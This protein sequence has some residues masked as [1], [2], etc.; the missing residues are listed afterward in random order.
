MYVINF[1]EYNSQSDRHIQNCMYE[2]VV[3][4]ALDAARSGRTCLTIA[5][6]LTTVRDADLICVL[7]KGVVVEKGNHEELMT[8]NGIYAE[9]Y[10]MHQVA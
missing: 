4:E 6:R 3:Q 9:L 10:M 7:K 2:K 1:Y 8:L 5:H